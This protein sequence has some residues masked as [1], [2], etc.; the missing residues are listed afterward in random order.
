LRRHGLDVSDFFEDGKFIPEL[1]PTLRPDLAVLLQGNLFNTD[2]V[3]LLHASPGRADEKWQQSVE[4]LL[5]IPVEIQA[6]RT[7][8]W[9]L[10]ESPLYQ[11]VQSFAEL[12]VALNSLSSTHVLKNA[13]GPLRT[14]KLSSDLTHFFRASNATDDMRQFLGAALEYLGALS[15]GMIEV[16]VAII[17]S[18]KE[19][20]KIAKI[21]EQALPPEKQRLLRFFMLQI[22][23]LA[24]ENG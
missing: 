24:G 8:I 10:L 21:E 15:E 9:D 18:M 6:W 2:I 17:R 3:S 7:R 13:P 19:V 20:E 11:R 14:S 1:L 23:R 22:A 12:A 4:R 5:N 16:P